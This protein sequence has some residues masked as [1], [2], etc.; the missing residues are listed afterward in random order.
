MVGAHPPFTMDAQ[1]KNVGKGNSSEMEQEKGSLFVVSYYLNQL[2]ELGVYNDCT[3][4]VTADHG[5]WFLINGPFNTPTSPILLVKP[6]GQTEE[7]MNAPVQV[8]HVPTGHADVPGTIMKAIL[9]D[10]STYGD[11]VFDIKE[12]SRPRFYYETTSDGTRDTSLI[13][14]VVDGEALDFSS[15]HLTG[16]VWTIYAEDKPLENNTEKP[17][18]NFGEIVSSL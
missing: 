9:G 4:I 2:K 18:A 15:W 6:A 11:T 17:P 7:E 13:E 10:A 8:S 14:W 5:D 1:G 3:I 12:G 16:N